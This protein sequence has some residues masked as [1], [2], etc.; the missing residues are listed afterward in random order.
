MPPVPPPPPPP[1]PPP[2]SYTYVEQ[3]PTD[4]IEYQSMSLWSAMPICVHKAIFFCQL[5]AFPWW[6]QTYLWGEGGYNPDHSPVS[7][8]IIITIQ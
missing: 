5:R 6:L 3:P 8:Y 1:P 4:I 7:L 2:S